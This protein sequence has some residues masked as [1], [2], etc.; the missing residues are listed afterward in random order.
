METPLGQALSTGME[1]LKRQTQAY[2]EAGV[3]YFTP[4]MI[5]LTNGAPIDDTSRAVR[6]LRA[7]EAENG[8]VVFPIAVGDHADTLFLAT[9]SAVQPPV[10]MQDVT[11]F[12]EFFAW[13]LANLDWIPASAW[14]PGGWTSVGAGAWGES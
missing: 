14:G 1:A 11:G 7:L 6:E 13:L 12:A 9:L 8:V 3:A 2:K 10:V 5:V 4:W